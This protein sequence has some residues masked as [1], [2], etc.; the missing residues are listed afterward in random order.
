MFYE[1]FVSEYLISAV[2]GAAP[3]SNCGRNNKPVLSQ[4]FLDADVEVYII[5]RIYKNNGVS[6]YLGYSNSFT[7]TCIDYNLNEI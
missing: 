6:F 3:I 7:T 2:S 4:P 5:K 1:F